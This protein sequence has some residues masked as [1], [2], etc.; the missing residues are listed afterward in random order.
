[1]EI[2]NFYA[3]ILGLK[4]PWEIADAKIDDSDK[5]VHLTLYHR[6]GSQF[7]C[8][9]C[10]N[11]CSV[12]DHGKLRTWRHL[13]TCDHYTYLHAYL[14]RV[15][16]LEH[17]VCTIEPSWSRSSSRFTLQFESFIIDTL[18]STQVRSRSALQLR[19]SEDQL[20]RIQNQAVKRGLSN[21]K[22]FKT[23]TS[24]IVRHVC[25]D[26]KSLFK[27]HHYV[28]ILYNGETG[29]VLEVVEHR[30]QEAA[31][32]AFIQLGQYIDLQGVQ[33]VTMD[34][35]KAFQNAAKLCIPS[36]D[37]VHDRF[38]L[39]QYLNN[40]VDITRRAENKKL[41]SQNDDRLK[42]TKYLWLKN[43][44]NLNNKQKRIHDQL[45]I[46]KELKT[47]K[48]W[49]I[50]EDFKKFFNSNTQQE[51][52]DFFNNWCKSID[53]INNAPLLKVAKTFRNHL[54]GLIDYYKHRVSNAMA[55]CVNMTIQQIKS[56]A[57]GFKSAKAF[58]IAIL[59]HLGHLNLYP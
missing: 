14:P 36:A 1:M 54:Q 29:S 4:L 53:K 37:I 23:S 22:K 46:D 28:S 50:K 6:A 43:L 10:K 41:M 42:G 27:G 18:Q 30:T 11:L 20:K 2:T 3:Q 56:K 35:W 49:K 39:A 45:I 12:H 44:D 55:E 47:V 40:A 52:I 15:K 38:H 59:F 24:Y 16:C 17:G 57:R 8:K 58:R 33:V 31:Q 5:S 7:P 13:D 34:M 25:I 19:V 9:H 32:N 21:R 48:A 51:A 26:E